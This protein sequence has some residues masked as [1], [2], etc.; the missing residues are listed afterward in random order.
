[1]TCHPVCPTCPLC[2][3]S[4][5]GTFYE[6]RRAYYRCS[7]CCLV[8]VLPTQFLAAPAEKAEYDRHQNSPQDPGYR[9]FL[10]RLLDPLA[11]RLEPASRGL[12]FGSG[13]GPTLSVMFQ[14]A[15]HLMEIFDPF[16]APNG[17][18]FQQQYDFITASE[19]VE[20]LHD[21]AEELERLWSCLK[22]G[23]L[24]GIMTKRVIDREAFSR[25]HYKADPTHVCFFA[26]ETFVWLAQRWRA[27]FTVAGK[28]VV[29][30]TKP[31]S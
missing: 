15:G 4:D 3:E 16:Y 21:P 18:V 5:T 11:A 6:D 29:V 10:Q 23:G 28:D 25:W 12:D 19:V 9:Q 30:F 22:P 26:L 2:R 14:E 31:S 24:L 8:F 27:E 17:N 7:T 20:H 1:M 13:P